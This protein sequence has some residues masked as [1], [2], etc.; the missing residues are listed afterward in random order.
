METINLHQERIK[1]IFTLL[2]FTFVIVPIVAGLD[3]FTDLLTNWDNYLNPA[4]AGMLLATCT[5]NIG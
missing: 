1:P 5:E 4:I 2:K 3:K